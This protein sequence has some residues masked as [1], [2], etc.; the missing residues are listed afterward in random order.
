MEEGEMSE[1]K[2]MLKSSLKRKKCV[3]N[4]S[5]KAKLLI[6][7]IDAKKGMTG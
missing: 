7:E 6:G 2:E 3:M 5:H 4:I 1:A